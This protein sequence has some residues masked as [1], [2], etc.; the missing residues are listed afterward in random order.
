MSIEYQLCPKVN[1]NLR[2]RTKIFISHSPIYNFKSRLLNHGKNLKYALHYLETYCFQS[3]ESYWTK[4][5]FYK[6]Q[7]HNIKINIE[8]LHAS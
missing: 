8:A 3:V 5:P 7:R 4:D 2:I 1:R 6:M